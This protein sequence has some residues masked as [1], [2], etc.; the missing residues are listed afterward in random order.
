MSWGGSE[1]TVAPGWLQTHQSNGSPK[2]E[3]GFRVSW[4]ILMRLKQR[5]GKLLLS[6]AAPFGQK[7]LSEEIF[8]GFV[9]IY[10]AMLGYIEDVWLGQRGW[11]DVLWR[12]EQNCLYVSG[13][14]ACPHRLCPPLPCLL[15]IKEGSE[16]GGHC[17]NFAKFS[18]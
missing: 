5:K 10:P 16:Q 4:A 9:G 3:F 6:L 18:L 1:K 11:T 12:D 13:Q 17:F 15:S 8:A 7:K 14:F 2:N